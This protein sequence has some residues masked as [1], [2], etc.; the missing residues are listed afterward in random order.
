MNNRSIQGGYGA[1]VGIVALAL[2]TMLAVV[3]MYL[4]SI[5]ISFFVGVVG[6]L[7]MK[8]LPDEDIDWSQIGEEPSDTW[9]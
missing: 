7:V 3:L 5:L 1:G 6:N 2:T 8:L 4:G 9:A